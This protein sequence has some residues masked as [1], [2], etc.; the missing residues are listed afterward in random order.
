MNDNIVVNENWWQPLQSELDN[1]ESIVFPGSDQVPLHSSSPS[2]LAT[3]HDVM[4][5]LANEKGSFF[6]ENLKVWFHNSDLRLRML[7]MGMIPKYVQRSKVSH[8]AP[9]TDE[10]IDPL[11]SSRIQGIMRDDQRYFK[12]HWKGRLPQG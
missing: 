7:D 12:R 11:F 10:I 6:N 2:C 9:E 4:Q 5:K 3:T 8:G 1:G